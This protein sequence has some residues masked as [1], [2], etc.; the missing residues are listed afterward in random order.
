MHSSFHIADLAA[1]L[2][3]FLAIASVAGGLIFS[4]DDLWVDACAFYHGLEPTR[5]S[6]SELEEMRSLPQ[7][8]IAIMVANWH[9]HEIIER[10]IAG[11]IAGLEYANYAFFLGVYPNDPLTAKRARALARRFP[12]VFV[13]VNSRPGPT[14]KGQM[15]NEIARAALASEAE[16]GAAYDLFLLHDSE[17]VLHP[18]SLQLF[19]QA[20][21]GADFAQIP[22]F[23]FDVPATSWTRGTY[24]DEFSESHTKDLLV[25]QRLGAAIP[26]AGVGTA[27]SR[28]LVEKYL[29]LGNGR[30][31]REDTVTEDYDL[32]L[33]AKALGLKSRFVCAY[34]LG[35]GGKKDFIATREYFPSSVGAAVRQKARWTLG[36]AFQGG[37]NF[38]WQ[39]SLVDRYFLFRDRRGPLN[40]VLS[41]ASVATLIGFVAAGAGAI[42]APAFAR[43]LPFAIPLGANGLSMLARAMQRCRAVALVH[44]PLHAL[45]VPFRWPLGIWL[46][47]AA[48]FR[49]Y[50]A[51]RRAGRTGKAPAWDKTAHEIPEAF[52]RSRALPTHAIASARAARQI[53]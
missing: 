5:L 31:L 1:A 10:M 12:N 35:P 18:L 42:E 25:R 50:R 27:L 17:D 15:L 48:A 3:G 14:T 38:G 19:N 29:E 13:V 9:E 51:F 22:V 47:S 6:A 37:E 34:R 46:N 53:L 39:G 26:S 44:G 30:L 4:F 45:A 20:S 23:S 2:F 49:A 24:L 40:A 41:V 8:R 33:R 11:N 21:R 32:G 7:K 16:S 36:I 52:G 28:K 43:G